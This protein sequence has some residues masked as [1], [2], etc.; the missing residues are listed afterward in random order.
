MRENLFLRY[1]L[2]VTLGVTVS[3]LFGQ[4][5]NAIEAIE[6]AYRNSTLTL[7]ST[8]LEIMPTDTDA[9]KATKLYYQAVLTVDVQHSIALHSQNFSR[10]RDE[11][12]GQ[13][14]GIQLISV[15][16]I[17]KEY[18]QALIKIDRINAEVLPEV[19]YWK[20]KIAQEMQ[21]YN[22]AIFIGENFINKY[23]DNHMFINVW[24]IVLESCFYK[25]D[26]NAFEQHLS[27]FSD[28]PEL[29]EYKPYL[30]YLNG[31]LYEVT[32]PTK[33]RNIFTQIINDF[34]LTQYRVQAEDRLYA[35]RTNTDR[36]TVTSPPAPQVTV[37]RYEDLEK[38]KWYV[39][40]IALNTEKAA[41]DYVETLKKNKVVAFH[42]SKP[43]N[44]KRLFAVV[45]GPFPSLKQAQDAKSDL[46]G[47]K[48]Q[49][50]IF[51]VE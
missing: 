39:Q 11:F 49:T 8:L 5:N 30:L 50:F 33:A 10:Y 37:S 44:D 15:D 3:F 22:E 43:V 1:F 32:N 27:A 38:N 42:I 20:A 47:K 24:L 26:I 14:S 12:Y 23:Q 21:R 40:F 46:E 25:N 31:M 2:L 4:K 51:K 48:Y 9:T 19:L 7:N 35:M 36:S 13:L 28:F 41:K 16:Y 45:Q 17:N 29:V 18:N 6:M 34:P